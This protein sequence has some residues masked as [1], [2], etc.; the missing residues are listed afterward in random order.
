MA[1]LP[2]G[3][4]WRIWPVGL[5]VVFRVWQ[6]YGFIYM[7]I[8][9]VAIL[10]VYE[11]LIQASLRY[12]YDRLLILAL[13]LSSLLTC[14]TKTLGIHFREK[15]FSEFSEGSWDVRIYNLLRTPCKTY[16]VSYFQ[17]ELLFFFLHFTLPME[18][19]YLAVKF[20]ADRRQVCTQRKH[21]HFPITPM[22]MAFT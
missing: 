4:K 13:S 9:R 2:C 12:M 16:A 14:H 11:Y 5:S 17:G 10:R 19:T 7:W 18:F 22:I 20:K 15:N 21:N 1:A 3:W 6:V 8:S